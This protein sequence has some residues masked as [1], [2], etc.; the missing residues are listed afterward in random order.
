[1]RLNE[2]IKTVSESGITVKGRVAEYTRE[3]PAATLIRLD[4]SLMNMPL[5]QI[6][7]DGMVRA[8]E[9]TGSPFGVKLSG[10]WSGYDSLKKAI[11]DHYSRIGADV[12]EGEI[13]VTTGLES[14]HSALSNL[15]SAENSVLLPDPCERR[16]LELQQLKGRSVGFLRATPE[17]G[18]VPLPDGAGADLIYLASPDPVTGAV[19][20]EETLKQWVKLALETDA[21]IL[22]D[23]SLS[24]YID[25]GTAP[26]SIYAIPGAKNCA[27][28]LFSFEKGYGVRELKIGYV[29][30]PSTLTRCETRIRDLFATRQP[31]TA[32]PP[33]FVMQTAAELLF[34]PEARE[35]TAK[36]IYR[37][38]KVARIL[39]DGLTRAGIPHVGGE[40]SPFLWAQCPRGMS[41]WQCFDQL[42]S[43][44]G[45]VVTPGSLFG[46]G[47]ERYIRLTAF[48]L[49]EEAEI[50]AQRLVSLY[51]V[52]P[53]EPA[54][55]PAAAVAAELL[56]DI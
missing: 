32:T 22:Y 15:F 28:E 39:S 56:K 47:G 31:A 10:P 27:M 11:S 3:H 38:K 42:L 51:A 45:L 19:I 23:A 8:V 14:S 5:P 7:L 20:S 17:N 55:P 41:G 21:V 12:R 53:K 50:A 25:E 35:A 29:V 44:A 26:R 46:Y 36:L 54:A 49:P 30:I 2:K 13:F 48:G 24:E 18:F 34:S 43:E 33:S 16:L 6:V 37:I 40:A 9:E 52:S 1:M 4:Q